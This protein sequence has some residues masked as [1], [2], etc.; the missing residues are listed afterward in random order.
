MAKQLAINMAAIL[1]GGMGL[2]MVNPILAYINGDKKRFKELIQFLD[3][4]DI[5]TQHHASYVL[6]HVAQK[7]TELVLPYTALFLNILKRDAIHES[8]KR[9][10]MRCFQEFDCEEEH[11]GE[12]LDICYAFMKNATLAPATIAFAVNV[13]A[14]IC[15]RYPDLIPEL[16]LV[17]KA[18]QANHSAPSIVASVKKAQKVLSKPAHKL[19]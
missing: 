12:L 9:N 17:L 10:V 15:K 13:S 7:Q 16:Q 5:S 1:D 19:K 6:T 3:K 8:T 11:A 14:P 4:G 2:Q 18:L